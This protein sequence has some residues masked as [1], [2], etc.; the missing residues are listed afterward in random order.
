MKMGR[1]DALR[2]LQA[3]FIEMPLADSSPRVREAW[4]MKLMAFISQLNVIV[5]FPVG[6]F[7]E[8][9]TRFLLSQKMASRNKLRIPRPSVMEMGGQ[10]IQDHRAEIVSLM[11]TMEDL[12]REDADD[13]RSDTEAIING[14]SIDRV[15]Q[16][17]T[18]K[19]L[20]KS[21]EKGLPWQLFNRCIAKDGEV[22]ID[23]FNQKRESIDTLKIKLNNEISRVNRWWKENAGVKMFS[24]RHDYI[25]LKPTP[26]RTGSPA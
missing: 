18:Y 21:Y 26:V 8:Q 3:L 6:Q 14:V 13:L 9:M 11:Q 15:E 22:S 16:K 20:T 17:V 23:E 25:K 2:K 7:Q 10:T 4:W 24:M 5:S 12:L 1:A 19:G